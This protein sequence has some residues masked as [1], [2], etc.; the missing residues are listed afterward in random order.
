MVYCTSVRSSHSATTLMPNINHQQHEMCEED[1][2]LEKSRGIVFEGSCCVEDMTLKVIKCIMIIAF[3]VFFSFSFS[4]LVFLFL[5]S[6]SPIINIISTYEP[7]YRISSDHLKIPH[8]HE[9]LHGPASRMVASP[10]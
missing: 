6:A 10:A 3:L 7:Y 2:D 8:V 9:H 4:F 1:V 5:W